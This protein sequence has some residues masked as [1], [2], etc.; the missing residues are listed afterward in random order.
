MI[1]LFKISRIYNIDYL[2]PILSFFLAILVI[3]T[4]SKYHLNQSYLG[5]T[6]IFSFL[7][8]IAFKGD[9]GISEE[10]H[11]PKNKFLFL[12]FSIIFFL[13]F[14][15]S[16]CLL[17]GDSLP[18][19]RPP[20]YFILVAAAGAIIS[21]QIICFDDKKYIN[22]ILFEIFLLA[23]NVR[24]SA[25]YLF[26]GVIGTD[27]WYHIGFIQELINNGYIP[28]DLT[29]ASYLKIPFMHVE[30]AIL[31]IITSL[32]LK[33]SFF[34]ISVYT[35]FST[36]FIY[37]I[38]LIIFDFKIGLLSALILNLSDQYIT[39]G[40]SITPMSLGLFFYILFIY[41]IFNYS[42]VIDTKKSTWIILIL[43]II[44]AVILTHTIAT[45][46]SLVL[47]LSF[48]GIYKLLYFSKRWFNIQFFKIYIN[49][50]IVLLFITAVI[51]YW[52]Y[53]F[54]DSSHHFF[55]S[56]IFVLKKALIS[57]EVGN[58]E[59]ITQV[60]KLDILSVVLNKVGYS[61]LVFLAF[62]GCFILV[63]LSKSDTKGLYL[64]FFCSILF[65]FIYIPSLVGSNA[66][67]PH[68]WFPFLYSM[69][70]ILSAIT[71]RFFTSFKKDHH[72]QFA[73]RFLFMTSLI[74]LLIFF[75]ITNSLT[76]SDSSIYPRDNLY[77]FSY[78]RSSFY[79][80]EMVIGNFVKN[81]AQNYPVVPDMRFV[82]VMKHWYGLNNVS[83][84][85][86]S[87][88]ESYD[89][90]LILLRKSIFNGYIADQS[91]DYDFTYVKFSDE[92]IK[93]FGS[94]NY[95]LVYNN[96]E[97]LG[98]LANHCVSNY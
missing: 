98:Q 3:L 15:L 86:L 35:V 81:N 58:V 54:G 43:L 90:G 72:Y 11:I 75:M 87:N 10:N 68:R 21:G 38:C 63:S 82:S 9:L 30:V 44:F 32:G 60:S 24:C 53:I 19:H 18:Y 6:I 26:P 31:D 77:D 67:L 92:F 39:W 55:D 76:N 5:I 83:Y 95:M 33:N 66:L 73:G 91:T 62:I 84:I 36:I 69:L 37:I 85:S 71:I 29:Y 80:S 23:L 78:S 56:V 93:Y 16:V 12:S 8:F 96:G 1:I 61:I 27:S 25:Y 79:E 14:I 49:T 7:F 52:M 50:N 64:V 2:L 57:S 4:S 42:R 22:L 28:N 34:M 47:F 41:F 45:F 89:N 17:R 88:Q 65:A 13:I 20:T 94:N 70:S 46:V 59:I 97:V 74:F 48:L 40:L 51:F